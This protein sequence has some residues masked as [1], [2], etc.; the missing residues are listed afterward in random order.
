MT[1]AM[2]LVRDM[3]EFC[4]RHGFRL[5]VRVLAALHNKLKHEST[6]DENTKEE[7]GLCFVFS[8]FVLS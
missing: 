5:P 3:A 1:R 2:Q 8:S 6:K 7:T 4:D